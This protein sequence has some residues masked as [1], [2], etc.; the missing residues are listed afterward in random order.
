MNPF[1]TDLAKEINTK[2]LHGQL[3]DSGR[4]I[5][6]IGAVIE[7]AVVERL[8]AFPFQY[9]GGGYFRDNRVPKGETAK[10]VHGGHVIGEI[11]DNI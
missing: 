3:N 9:E 1:Y 5:E 6:N 2:V 8:L 11:I 4:T 7:K 10:I